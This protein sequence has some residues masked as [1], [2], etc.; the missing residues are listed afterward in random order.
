MVSFFILCCTKL[1]GIH[2]HCFLMMHTLNPSLNLQLYI[3]PLFLNGAHL[4]PLPQFTVVT[5]GIRIDP[6]FLNG[7]LL[8]LNPSLSVSANV[9]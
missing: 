5:P 8:N 6:L 1:V 7:A 2:T 3:D 4:K 9:W